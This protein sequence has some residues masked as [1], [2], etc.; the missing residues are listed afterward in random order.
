MRAGS[1]ARNSFGRTVRRDLPVTRVSRL[2]GRPCHVVALLAAVLAVMV[3][4][5]AA[6]PA[7]AATAFAAQNV[8]GAST[9]A[10]QVAVGASAS[11]TAGQRLGSDPPRPGVVVATG[12]AANTAPEVAQLAKAPTVTFG[13]GA[14]HLEGTD[15][16]VT[17]VESTILERVTTATTQATSETGSFWGRID[18]SGTTIEYRA[19]TLPNGTVNVGTYYVP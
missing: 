11:I 15:L 10:G 5:F 12:V 2:P 6:G 7:S 1:S 14:R 17:E 19:Y 8:V 18:I 13:H 4:L 16:S 9:S 3:G